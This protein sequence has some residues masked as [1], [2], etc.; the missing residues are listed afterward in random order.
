[1][2]EKLGIFEG[3]ANAIRVDTRRIDKR[4]GTNIIDRSPN[5]QPFDQA[6]PLAAWPA[7]GDRA[8]DDAQNLQRLFNLTPKIVDRRFERRRQNDERNRRMLTAIART[9]DSE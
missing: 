2:Q 3:H 9:R 4:Q 6:P 1:M 5:A 8:G 7:A